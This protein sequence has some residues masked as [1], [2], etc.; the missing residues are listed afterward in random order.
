MTTLSLR[1]IAGAYADKDAINDN[2]EDIQD[3]INNLTTSSTH[4]Y[5]DSGSA[6]AIGDA[7]Y[8]TGYNTTEEKPTIDL[9]DA[10]GTATMPCIGVVAS[11]MNDLE[12]GYVTSYG[13]V[14]G[15]DTSSWT[16]GDC[17]WLHTTAGDLT[18]TKP[19]AGFKQHMGMVVYSDATNGIIWVQ[20]SITD[21]DT[22]C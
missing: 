8:I 5:N 9:A 11:A 13:L 17:L 18:S 21:I 4:V 20:P 15:F 16:A 19:A 14:S 10:D 7:V 3:A 22:E 12:S 1:S 6:V 2:F